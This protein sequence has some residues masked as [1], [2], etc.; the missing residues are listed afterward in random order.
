MAKQ[1]N[2]TDSK[3]EGSALGIVEVRGATAAIEA[4]DAM[5]KTADVAVTRRINVMGGL[6]TILVRG[7]VGSVEMATAAGSAA[8]MKVGELLGSHV[9]PRPHRDL[10][11]ILDRL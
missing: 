9:I 6:V 2:T 4:G 10:E 1:T 7:D 3:H 5:V 11:R 8:A